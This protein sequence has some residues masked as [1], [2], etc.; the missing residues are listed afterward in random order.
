MS[1]YLI[2]LVM[3]GRETS[4]TQSMQPFV[5]T[6]SPVAERDQRIGMVGFEGFELGEASLPKQA[7]KPEL[8]RGTFFNRQCHPVS[9]RP[10]RQG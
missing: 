10:V 9:R 7:Q 3:R 5:R 1:G 8:S 2:R 4:E 6:T